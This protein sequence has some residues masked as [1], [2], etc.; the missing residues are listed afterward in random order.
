MDER[1]RFLRSS[2]ETDGYGLEVSEGERTSVRITAG[3]SACADCLA[4][5]PVLREVLSKALGVPAETID[6]T[7]PEK[8]P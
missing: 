2:L 5:E 8:S 6:L 7:Y 1:L 4:P 3:P